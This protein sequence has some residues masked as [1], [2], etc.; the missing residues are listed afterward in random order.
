MAKPLALLNDKVG[1]AIHHFDISGKAHL[2]GSSSVRGMLYASDYDIE[3]RLQ[4]RAE[5][6]AHHLQAA[7][8]DPANI[9]LEFKCGLGVDITK[10]PFKKRVAALHGDARDALVH[11]LKTL[12]WS[13]ADVLKGSI[14]MADGRVKTL[15]AALQEPAMIKLDL[16]VAVG[17]LWA[18]VSEVYLYKQHQQTKTQLAV[19]LEADIDIYRF[20]DSM[21]CLKR[22]YSLLALDAKANGPAMERLQDF[23]NGPA[24]YANKLRSDI[25]FLLRIAPVVGWPRLAPALQN[26]KERAGNLA[27][28]VVNLSALPAMARA[29]R[30]RVN[31]NSKE[32]LRAMI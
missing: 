9:I 22:F 30:E 4:G 1:A 12:R 2:V 28:V 24:G 27:G 5:T 6:L 3:T 8:R 13:R 18:E 16:A 29:L 14:R 15:A 25:D 19:E 23:F 17:D 32:I 21:K 26:V 20:S 7:F 10:T 11:D 31:A